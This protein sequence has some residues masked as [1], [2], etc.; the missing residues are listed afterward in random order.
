MQVKTIILDFDGTVY[1]QKP[2]QLYNLIRI[3]LT[4]TVKPSAVSEIRIIS[5][6][7]K[8][9]EKYSESSTPILRVEDDLAAE[10]NQSVEKIKSIRDYWLIYSQSFSIKLFQRV[11]LLRK[12]SQ[13]QRDGILIILWS[14]YPMADKSKRLKLFPDFSF[15]SEDSTI[16]F[17]KPSGA[18]L[19]HIIETLQLMKNEVILIG[20][21][22][23]R[24]G[25]AAA[26]VGI[27]Y[28]KIGRKAN[29]ILNLLLKKSE[30]SR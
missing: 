25:K 27:S 12:I 23:D 19:L 14:D 18:G 15:C 16:R 11:F 6:Y 4:I 2:V 9:R 28:F 30:G 20:D 13:L 22:D 1:F 8:M 21:R 5:K 26:A 7:R 29:H 10:L 3:I 24:D 17:A